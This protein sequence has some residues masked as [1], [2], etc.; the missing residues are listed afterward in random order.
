M[1]TPFLGEIRMFG[2]NFA[3][4]G[5]TLCNGALLSISQNTALFA[6]LGTTYGGDGVQ[7]F[8]LPNLQCRSPVG[9]GSG[10]GLTPRVIGEV[11]GEEQVT[12]TTT[13]MPG[14]NHTFNASTVT[15]NAVT[16]GNAVLP[17]APPSPGHLYIANTGSPPPK[18]GNL[19]AQ[20]IGIS[21]GGVPHNNIMP[22]LCVT[23]IIA[24]QGVFPTRN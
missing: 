3:P 22:T 8:A 24:L 5:W 4:S 19:N 9:Q 2:G 21:S 20:S 23:F 11:G 15:A 10:L 6:L 16:I 14:H 12:I 13:T 17:G 18:F 1:A 7:T